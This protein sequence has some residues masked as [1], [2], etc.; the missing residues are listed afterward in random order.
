MT[1]AVVEALQ[2]LHAISS[3]CAVCDCWYC[4]QKWAWACWCCWACGCCQWPWLPMLSMPTSRIC[5]S[6]SSVTLSI[7]AITSNQPP[8]LKSR[9]QAQRQRQIHQKSSKFNA[10]TPILV[11]PPHTV[12]PGIIITVIVE[13]KR[14]RASGNVTSAREM[15]IALRTRNRTMTPL[16]TTL[17]QPLRPRL[18]EE[19]KYW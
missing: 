8:A 14:Q 5:M 19:K 7:M 12:S 16:Q 2:L 18:A 11:S 10:I 13:R 1:R 3:C 9:R 17:P 4:C 6:T 15:V